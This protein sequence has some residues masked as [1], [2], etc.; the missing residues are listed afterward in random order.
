MWS[1]SHIFFLWPFDILISIFDWN[2]EEESLNTWNV[3][4]KWLI[5]HF[6]VIWTFFP[7]IAF[8]LWRLLSLFQYVL[9]ITSINSNLYID[10][11]IKIW[12]HKLNSLSEISQFLSF[13]GHF[14]GFSGNA[15]CLPCNT[16]SISINCLVKVWSNNFEAF[17]QN[18]PV[19]F[20][21]A[22]VFIDLTS[23][24]AL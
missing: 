6:F 8:F 23:S 7:N 10:S 16:S 24:V 1:T 15:F 11:Q 2:F 22:A 19:L 18:Y 9:H 21:F 20:I 4:F 5:L 3:C 12:S 17:F 13:L 14:L